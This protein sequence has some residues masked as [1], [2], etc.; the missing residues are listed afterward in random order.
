MYVRIVL[1]SATQEMVSGGL[2][3]D[4]ACSQSDNGE[5]GVPV[6]RSGVCV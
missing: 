5:K 2:F 3:D 6:R 1:F 4:G